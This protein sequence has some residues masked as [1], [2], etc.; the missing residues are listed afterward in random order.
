[1]HTYRV[2]V[3]TRHHTDT[4]IL[5]ELCSAGLTGLNSVTAGRLFFLDA[6]F[7]LGAA[8]RIASDL[9]SD[10]VTEQ[11]S[12]CT[13]NAQ[14]Q[15]APDGIAL[16]IHPRPG[17][18][19]PVAESTLAE[20]RDAGH[21][22]SAVRTARRLVL[23]GAASAEAVLATARRAL[24]NE[25]IE[26]IVLGTAGVRPPPRPAERGFQ[27]VTVLLRDLESPALESLSRRGHLFLSLTEMQ[28][29]QAHYL[30]LGRDPTDLELETL[31]QT[32]SEH[33]VHKTLKSL[34]ALLG[35]T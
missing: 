34:A 29:I 23:R 25:S 32:W 22:V 4:E 28:A 30:T 27:L 3:T 18:M 17:V 7:D 19:D 26:E 35:K 14:I 33:C 11:I 8:Q 10:P 1:M 16:E 5:T 6:G 31:A 9:L 13:E 15:A 12:V 2:E 24:A 20:L 21:A